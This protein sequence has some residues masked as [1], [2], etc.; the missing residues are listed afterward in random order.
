MPSSTPPPNSRPVVTCSDVTQTFTRGGASGLFSRSASGETVTAVSDV[1]LTVSTGE[2]VGI[3]GPSGSGKS[4]LLHLLAGLDTPTTG[5]VT[6]SGTDTQR[7]SS[8]RR[9][10]LRLNHVGIVFQ[11][12]HLLPSLSAR[13]NVA[14]PLIEAGYSKQKRRERAESVLSQVGLDDRIHHTPSELSGG[15]QQRVAVARALVTDPDLVIADEPTGELDTATGEQVLDLLSEV[16][17]D[18]AVIVASH[19]QQVLDR[20]TRLVRLRD[21]TVEAIEPQP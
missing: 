18:R 8:R 3:A 5:T 12:F 15:E 9:T 17:D 2:F 4:T 7:V 11:H 20:I 1:S 21:G 6:L 10:Q 14:V 13:G 19:D 16:A